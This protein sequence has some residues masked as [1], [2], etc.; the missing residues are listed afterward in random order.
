M[1]YDDKRQN[2][3]MKYPAV[4]DLRIK[5]QKRIPN[6]AWAYMETGTT[7]ET[8]LSV[9]RKALHDIRLVPRFCK[10]SLSPEI[11][12]TFLDQEYDAPFGIAPIGLAGLMWPKAEMY[13]GACGYRY[14]IPASLSTVATE[15]P[16]TVGPHA[17]DMGWFQ[18]YPPRE[19]ELRKTLLDRAKNAGY[20]TLIITVDI[21]TPSRRERTKR[22]GLTT[23]PKMTPGFIW[24]GITHPK[25][26]YYTLRHGIPRL[27]TIEDYSDFKSMMSVGAFVQG[28]L[29]GNISWEYIK[30][31][32]D[33]WDGPIILK[34]ILHP[35]DALVAVKLG[36]DAVVVSNHGARQFDGAPAAIDCLR[37]IVSAVKGK[38][39]IAFDSGI[40]TGLDLLR[41][42]YYGAEFCLVGRPYLYGVAALGAHGPSHVT[43]ILIGDLKNNMVQMG[44]SSLDQL[45][46]I[47]QL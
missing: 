10:G 5:A 3:M 6:V 36:L 47:D 15:T 20:K 28:Q 45:S 34:G 24:Q 21:P 32:R 37:P 13:F 42:Y 19:P 33:L 30:E 40:R 17:K 16:E 35:E 14:R 11:K 26:S 41:A 38:I 39:G 9:N 12:T 22:A 2:L 4:S 23:P 29:G 43:E 46:D 8:L 31:V 44:I 7:E 27:R 25:W 1:S 18:L